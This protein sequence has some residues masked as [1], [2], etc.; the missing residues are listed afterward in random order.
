MPKLTTKP[1]R[2]TPTRPLSKQRYA[3]LV[4]DVQQLVSTATGA[5][6]QGKVSANW[7]LGRRI[8][9]ER[10]AQDSGYHNSV[11]RDLSADTR[12]ALRTLQYAVKFH[13][14]YRT[15]PK[16]PLNWF[17]YRVLLDQSSLAARA[18]Y[19]QLAIDQ[20]LAARQLA[21]HIAQERGTSKRSSTALPRPADANYLY[22]VKVEQ[23]IDGDTFDLSIDLGFY[24][25]RQGRFRLADIDCPELP[26]QPAR[27][28]RDFVIQC[29]L[30]AQT[31]VVKTQRTD[32]HGRYVTHLFYSDEDL[33]TRRLLHPRHPPQ[34][35]A[36]RT[37]PRRARVMRAPFEHN[38]AAF[39]RTRRTTDIAGDFTIDDVLQWSHTPKSAETSRR[40][41]VQ[42]LRGL[43]SI[44]PHS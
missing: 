17:H 5:V 20:G 14:A 11:L 32:L 36:G 31:I 39:L 18:R 30:T 21:R 25:R 10:L 37:R 38:G 1:D 6:D 42:P 34:Q 41:A 19:Q 43:A 22:R 35:R 23:V 26:S 13:Q 24:V 44:E 29:L 9:R 7:N 28:A 33:P 12:V 27:A 2:P 4:R 15:C 8:A 16:L 40:N 3:E